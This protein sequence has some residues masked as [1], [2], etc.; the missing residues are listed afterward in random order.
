M[1]VGEVVAEPFLVG[2]IL[3]VFGE[4]LVVL[5]MHLLDMGQ[6]FGTSTHEKRPSS[7]QIAGG[8]K[9]LGV[10]V[11]QGKSSATHESRDFVAIDGIGFHL[12]DEDGFHVE[13]VPE[14]E[15]DLVFFQEIGEP[16]PI[17]GGF[18]AD[19]EI[20]LKGFEGGKEN[21]GVFALKVFVQECVSL[22]VDNANV[23]RCGVQVD[24]AVELAL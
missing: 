5:V 12:S 10:D 13:S 3:D 1:R 14:N 8:A 16:I 9:L 20:F 24:A 11:S 7:Q 15:L 2:F 23:Q 22:G 6:A 21:C 4:S 18:A 19:N 17:E